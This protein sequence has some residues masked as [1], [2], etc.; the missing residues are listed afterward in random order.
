MTTK[1]NVALAL[2]TRAMFT[3]SSLDRVRKCPPS[4]VLHQIRSAGDRADIGSAMHEH[5]AIRTT[6]GVAVAVELLD[7]TIRRW[8]LDEKMAGILRARCMH[9][10][11][12]PPRGAIAEQALCLCEDGR[13]VTVKG[14]RGHY[15]DL[16]AG[17]FYALTIDVMWSEP[18][19]LIFD[20]CQECGGEGKLH[21]HPCFLDGCDHI[22]DAC[23][24]CGG[25]PLPPRCPP[26]SVLWAGDYK[27]GSEANV[28]GV[29]HNA[30]VLSG[31][32]LAA[33]WTGAETV[34]PAVIY[35]RKG[36]GIWD[37]PEHS[38]GR[39]DL[40]PIQ[41]M[42]LDTWARVKEQQRKLAAGEPLD[43]RVGSQ[44]TYCPA[45][46]RCAAKIGMLKAFIG[47]PVPTAQDEFSDEELAQLAETLPQIERL[48]EGMKRVLKKISDVRP[49][50]ISGG[51]L[52]GPHPVPQTVI[53][54]SIAV[55]ILAKEVGEGR[56]KQAV[57]ETI[58]QKA[59]EQ[60]VKE[61]HAERGIVRKVAPTMRGLMAQIGQAGGLLSEE[62]TW[63]SPYKPAAEKAEA[64][65][66]D[67]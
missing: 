30:Q 61:V 28:E 2:T 38:F 51:R 45:E 42:L 39:A 32:L 10:E 66:A 52:W 21:H 67:E 62:E 11:W 31:A 4:A 25:E 6:R 58:S 48:A 22:E 55:P 63:Y 1:P 24:A 23:A 35:P 34:L 26:G 57:E 47:Q 50:A 43:F 60:A 9:F 37:L 44:C 13:V 49:L 16:P 33:I 5:M 15:P 18:E 3:G 27:T 59:M 64:V 29:E 46:V 14:G 8:G 56:A 41:E 36:K 12:C 7:E 54:P 53:V 17:G 19:P 40:A 65:E 20:V